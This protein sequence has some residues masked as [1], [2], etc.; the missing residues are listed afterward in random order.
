MRYGL[1]LH[2]REDQAAVER[3]REH[4]GCFVLLTNVSAEGEDAYSA[5]Q[6]VRT[7]KEQ[8]GIEKNFG[9]LKDDAIVNALFLKNP[10]RIEA[11][12]LILLIA[13]LIWR[14]MEFHMRRHLEQ[15]GDQLPGWD[16]KPTTRPTAYMVTIKFKGVLIIK[17]DSERRLSRPLSSTQQAFLQALGL[18]ERI[19]LQGQKAARW[20]LSPPRIDDG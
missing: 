16:N 5:E 13:L 6:I 7:Y 2:A 8:H 20:P 14:L 10:E 9:F 19:F 1:A 18:G 12:G 4:S 15:S 17:H 3:A 11:L